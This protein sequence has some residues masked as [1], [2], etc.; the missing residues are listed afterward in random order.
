M[1][2]SLGGIAVVVAGANTHPLVDG[3]ISLSG[4][5][6]YGGL[7]ATISARRLQVPILYLA[8]D[9]DD[10]FTDDARTPFQATTE[11]DKALELVPGTEHGVQLVSHAEQARTLV[12][13]F[14]RSH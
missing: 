2:A 12:E 8:A 10:G 4:P 7:D 1:G 13:D 6:N 3:V 9:N 11:T 5:A 14:I